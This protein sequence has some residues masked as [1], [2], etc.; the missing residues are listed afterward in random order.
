MTRLRSRLLVLIALS[1]LF[2]ALTMALPWRN[3]FQTTIRPFCS[4]LSLYA[5]SES[6]LADHLVESA[7]G[8]LYA[9]A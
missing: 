6:L 2:P 9:H 3:E 1:L 4:R 8:G 7:A 5:G